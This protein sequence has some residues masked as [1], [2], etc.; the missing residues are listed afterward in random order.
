MAK[1]YFSY[2]TMNAGK[3]DASEPSPYRTHEPM[4]GRPVWE[5]PQLKKIWAGEWL[6]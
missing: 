3:S 1:L 5:N 6:N 2:S 4:Q